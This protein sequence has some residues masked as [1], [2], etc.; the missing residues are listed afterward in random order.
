MEKYVLP[1][2]DPNED[3]ITF[4]VPDP[5]VAPGEEPTNVTVQIFPEDLPDDPDRVDDMCNMLAYY[6]TP[7]SIWLQIAVRERSGRLLSIVGLCLTR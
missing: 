1:T 6:M 4:K 2:V 7:L 5:D 3:G